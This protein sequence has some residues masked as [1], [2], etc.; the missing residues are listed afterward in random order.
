ML[1]MQYEITDRAAMEFARAFY[2]A[3]ADGLAVDAAVSEA[4]KA[5]SLEVAN[6][7]EWDTG[8]V[9]A[10]PRW[11]VIRLVAASTCRETTR[12][13]GH[14]CREQNFRVARTRLDSRQ[15]RLLSR[16]RLST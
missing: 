9:Y 14:P 16:A 10:D 6:T 15:H 5:V 12:G 4:R 1:A 8:A 2:E 7:V 11:G 3:L 13:A